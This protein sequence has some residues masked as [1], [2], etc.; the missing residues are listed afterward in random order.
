MNWLIHLN[1]KLKFSKQ[2]IFVK[3]IFLITLIIGP[4]IVYSQDS[5]IKFHILGGF[6]TV[7]LSD[8]QFEHDTHPD[9]YFLTNSN[10]PGS[11]GTTEMNGRH[12]YLLV[13]GGF[14]K[15]LSP[16]TSLNFDLGFLFGQ[17][18]DIQQNLN[19]VRH[20]HNAAFI[21]SEIN[22]GILSAA[23]IQYNIKK[24]YAGAD[25]QVA[26]VFVESGWDRFNN[27]ESVQTKLE[28]VPSI[29][30]KIGFYIFE[31]SIHFGKNVDY[32]V[33]AVW[34]F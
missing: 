13:G 22:W 30:P 4:G 3:Y 23:G 19:D 10:V 34:K 12:G 9:D 7:T 6:R 16:L 27:D 5:K 2:M 25:V 8:N 17:N 11:A 32:G 21:Y 18:R 26:G 24:F 1:F 33:Q 20:P 14:E 29:G 31:A 28:L 15:K